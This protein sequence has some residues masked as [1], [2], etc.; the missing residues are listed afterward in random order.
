M[1]NRTDPSAKQIH[2]MNPQFLLET[3]L[4]NKIYNTLYWKEKCFALTS[5]TIIDRA[6]ELKYIGGTYG[7]T[8]YPTD[9]ICLVLKMLQIQPSDEIIDEYLSDDI[10]DYKYLR[11]LTAFY[12]RLTARSPNVYKKLEPLY[13][14]YRKLRVRY[15]DGSYSILHM[16]EFIESLLNSESLFEVT[17]PA[18]TKR[19][20]LEQ[21]GE[22][23]P[24]MSLLEADLDLDELMNDKRIDTNRGEGGNEYKEYKEQREIGDDDYLNDLNLDNLVP[25]DDKNNSESSSESEDE[26]YKLKNKKRRVEEPIER[27]TPEIKK[28]VLMRN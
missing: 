19:R 3:I 22:L 16:D 12:V 13:N 17:L 7:A 21:N 27:N 5:E 11:A 23:Q 1:S 2:G 8:K 10:A 28:R 15:P 20:I 18:L 14:D 4:R 9:F 25:D 26:D 6:I 24:R